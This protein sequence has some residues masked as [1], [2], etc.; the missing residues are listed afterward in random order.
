MNNWDLFLKED[1]GYAYL[2]YGDYLPTAVIP[3]EVKTAGKLVTD[4][5]Y[6]IWDSYL[7]DD[8]KNALTTTE[9]WNQLISSDL[10]T[11]AENAGGTA[12]AT[13]GATETQFKDSWN[14]KYT[15]AEQQIT[16]TVDEDLS[17]KTGYGDIMYFPHDEEVADG[18]YNCDGYWLSSDGRIYDLKC[19]EY[20]G[21]IN[22][23]QYDSKNIAI[24]P[25][26]RIPASILI[27]NDDQVTWDIK[28]VVYND[29]VEHI[30]PKVNY[31][32]KVNYSVTVAE[33]T[34]DNWK[35]FMKDDNGY[36]YMIYGD[37]LPNDCISQDAISNGRLVR[38]GDYRVY[39][40]DRRD[41]LINTLKNVDYWSNLVTSELNQAAQDV[42]GTASATGGATVAQLKKSWNEKYTELGQQ[43]ETSGS[44]TTAWDSENL[45]TTT[46][47]SV[48][49]SDNMYFPHKSDIGDGSSC[50][51]YWLASIHDGYGLKILLCDGRLNGDDYDRTYVALRPLIRI[52]EVLL[53]YDETSE[54]W[55]I[56]YGD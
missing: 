50:R 6:R 32:Q 7:V 10:Q 19:I 48:D 5:T 20:N 28:D 17:T 55:N 13:G 52:P 18:T 39:T 14:G 47:Y 41:T 8:L 36:A 25:I 43:M 12:T 22:S 29:D 24:R 11:S 16:A 15:E 44:D 56:N 40:S 3:E 53:E 33:H 49:E 26:I 2:I 35:L 34:L 31:G 54:E 4:G 42:S 23:E 37:Y 46:G 45:S 38:K 27:A 9:Y 21:T 51:G 30:V 1:D